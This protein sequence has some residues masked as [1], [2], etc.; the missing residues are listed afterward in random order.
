VS[1]LAICDGTAM[2]AAPATEDFSSVR[3]VSIDI[4]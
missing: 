3:R 4:E 2:A 1:K